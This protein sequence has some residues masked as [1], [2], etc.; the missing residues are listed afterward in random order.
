MTDILTQFEYLY[1]Q[2]DRALIKA[3]ELTPAEFRDPGTVS[4]RDLRSTFV[5]ELD[6]ERSWLLRL[7]GQ[8]RDLWDVTLEAA[9]YQDVAT[10]AE[11]WQR[12]EAEALAWLSDL[13]ESDLAAPN[14]ENGLEGFPL[15]TYL[16]HVV[17]HGVE[18]LSAAAILLDRAGHPMGDVGFL[19]F[20][21]A[22]VG[23]PIAEPP[24]GG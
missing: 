16:E 8:P 18:S 23:R 17:M 15:S 4:W 2:R 1:W 10:I 13:T 21:D 14:T 7:R 20:I 5:H 12:D 19:D 9:D 6:V 3:A 11:E 22:T 24:P